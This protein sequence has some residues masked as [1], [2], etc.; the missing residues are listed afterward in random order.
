MV[1]LMVTVAAVLLVGVAT[2]LLVVALVMEV[3]V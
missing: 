2:V 1:G 3:V